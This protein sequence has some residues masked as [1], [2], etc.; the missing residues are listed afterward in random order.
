MVYI[1][2]VSYRLG[3]GSFQ[4][5]QERGAS[6]LTEKVGSELVV[7]WPKDQ[8]LTARAAGVG[9]R[10]GLGMHSIAASSLNQDNEMNY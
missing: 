6:R 4:S 7:E 3:Y 8:K 2:P 9:P 1:R 10:M 5:I